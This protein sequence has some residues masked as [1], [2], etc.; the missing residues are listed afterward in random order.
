MTTSYSTPGG[1]GLPQQP[2]YPPVTPPRPTFRPWVTYVLLGLSVVVFM[3]QVASEL[4]LGYDLPAALGVKANNLIEQGQLWRLF[5]PM[6]LHG[7]VVH[8]ALNMYALMSFGPL[9]ERHFGRWRYLSL[10]VLSGFTGNVL[11]FVLSPYPSLGASTSIF[12]L[13]GAETIFLYQNKSL[14]G[15][16]A[17]RLLT[18]LVVVAVLNLSLGAF[19]QGIDA[20][21]HLGGLL[22]GAG[23]AWFGGPRL[24]VSSGYPVFSLVDVREERSVW[25]AGAAI[26]GVFAVMAA[27]AVIFRG[28]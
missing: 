25:L 14:L 19:S 8:I 7:S 17:R 20:W 16:N 1:E 22:G 27:A 6:L 11:S 13:L 24:Q 26:G 12:G 15:E 5:T 9:L 21:G 10:Y 23:F 28:G 3:G 18:N 2:A 4:I